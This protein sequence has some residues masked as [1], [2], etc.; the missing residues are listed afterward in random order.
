MV[1]INS[2]HHSDI[3]ERAILRL[4]EVMLSYAPVSGGAYKQ[5]DNIVMEVDA[6]GQ[7][8]VRFAPPP[9]NETAA[10]SCGGIR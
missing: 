2:S 7:R 5:S 6:A 4:H 3:R 9:A 8:R 1:F 10:A